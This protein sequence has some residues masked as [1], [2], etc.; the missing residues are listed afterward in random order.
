MRLFYFIVL[1]FSSLLLTDIGAF[2]LFQIGT[3]IYLIDIFFACFILCFAVI[4][5]R[6]KF[7]FY[8]VNRL[9]LLFLFILI[10]SI[11]Y[12]IT[13]YGLGAIGEGRYVYWLFFFAVPVYF[14]Q[15]RQIKTIRDLDKFFK[16]SYL[17][18]V[19][20]VLILL[21][22]EIIN[23]GRFFLA[24]QNRQFLNLEDERGLRF[25]G[26]EETFHLGTAVIFLIIDQ[27]ISRKRSRIKILVIIF[28]TAVILFTKN[29]TA[30]VS[31]FLSLA[32]V[33]I[34]EGKTK[35]F[36]K[37]ALTM[38]VLIGFSF[39]AFPAFTQSIIAPIS[40]VL[41]ISKDQTG[42]WR[43]LVQ[44]VAV[45]EG[46]KTPVFGQGFGGY[47]SYYVESLGQVINYPPH[48]MYVYLFQKAGI[49]GLVGYLGALF[50]LVRESSTLKKFTTNDK[51]SEKY[52]LLFKVLLIAQIPYGFAYFFSTFMG[53]YIGLFIVLKK[54]NQ[55][56]FMKNPH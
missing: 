46:L 54:L 3:S 11:S 48:S 49:I 16:L 35:T 4:G 28:L 7:H 6:T 14:Y 40:G 47:F 43:L 53:F 5:V 22:I 37:I 52:R 24:P 51:T 27:Y 23:G 1:F 21:T 10:V 17:L 19:V 8:D 25:L 56:P 2:P 34:L 50:S 13:K 15:T 31:L 45:Q 38:C 36:L 32:A 33:F 26:T 30:T 29:R 18:I 9:F 44:A 41:N 20:S 55:H 39:I 42:N 12:G